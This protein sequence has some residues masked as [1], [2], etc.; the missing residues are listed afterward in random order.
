MGL[1]PSPVA[2]AVSVL[3]LLPT[4]GPSVQLVRPAIPE[5]FVLTTAGLAGTV[6]PPP[7]VTVNVTATAGTG[8]PPASVTRTDG[9]A[10]TA[11][12][13]VAL[14]EVAELAVSVV[15][16]PLVPEAANVTGLPASP[17]AAAVTELLFVP[18]AG[19]R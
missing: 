8:F 18:A 16:V 9:G 15:A 3:L 2:L 17:V 10:L 19:P 1:P 14:C 11:V 5:A 12:P 7:A 6:D 13:T 4:A